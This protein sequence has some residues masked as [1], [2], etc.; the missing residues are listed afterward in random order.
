MDVGN[1][2]DKFAGRLDFSNVSADYL[3]DVLNFAQDRN[4]LD[5]LIER[6]ESLASWAR[7]DGDIVKIFPDFAPYSFLFTEFRGGNRGIHG[8][9]IYHGSGDSGV[10]APSFSARIGDLSETWQIHT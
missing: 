8:G 7:N 6:F 1:L 3:Q 10:G 4:L 5:I 9:L 2:I